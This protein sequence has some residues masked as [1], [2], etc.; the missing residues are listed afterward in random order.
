MIIRA[1]GSA[2]NPAIIAVYGAVTGGIGFIVAWWRR[3]RGPASDLVSAE[4]AQWRAGSVLSAVILVGAV[5]A[6]VMERS[7][8]N[9][10]SRLISTCPDLTGISVRKTTC[11]ALS[12]PHSSH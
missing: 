12:S 1:G 11:G 3:T 4:E 5:V 7:A 2:V 8:G 10:T 6:V 9:Y